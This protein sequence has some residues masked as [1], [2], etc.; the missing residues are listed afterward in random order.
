MK[1]NLL[2]I[3]GEDL[4]LLI[5]S[6]LNATDLTNLCY[7]SKYY[8]RLIFKTF[9]KYYNISTGFCS[10][11]LWMNKIEENLWGLIEN[12][13]N[14]LNDDINFD[15]D[16]NYVNLFKE[17][18]HLSLF[19]VC[20]HFL[21]CRRS[22]ERNFAGYCRM[23][24]RVRDNAFYE[25]NAFLS[26]NLSEQDGYLGISCLESVAFDAFLSQPGCFPYAFSES[27][28]KCTHHEIFHYT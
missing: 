10:I 27:G 1:P 5:F 22:C 19:S 7:V 11:E 15:F 13:F 28:L 2:Q 20:L 9:D 6:Y 26:V 8:R 14:D 4:Q 25:F 3:L 21:R 16:F 17:F 12:I 18:R 23:C 24:S